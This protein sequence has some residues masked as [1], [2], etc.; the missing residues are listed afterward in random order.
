M[1]SKIISKIINAVG[2]NPS[3]KVMNKIRN[4]VKDD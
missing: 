3:F 2:T 4:F 1:K